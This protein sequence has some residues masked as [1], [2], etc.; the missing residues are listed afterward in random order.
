MKWKK[1]LIGGAAIFPLLTGCSG[2]GNGETKQP[3]I[4]F[5]MS[6][7]HAIQAISAYRH[8]VSQLAPTPNI[9]RLA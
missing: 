2:G 1:F 7:D 3:N 4:L 8:P 5:I 9:D 6:D